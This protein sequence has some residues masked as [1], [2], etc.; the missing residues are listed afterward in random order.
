MAEVLQTPTTFSIA[1]NWQTSKYNLR[2]VSQSV[3]L[4]S[5]RETG[6]RGTSFQQYMRLKLFFSRIILNTFGFLLQHLWCEYLGKGLHPCE[7]VFPA[8]ITQGPLPA[9]RPASFP[10]ADQPLPYPAQPLSRL[11]LIQACILLDEVWN[12]LCSTII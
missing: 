8:L 4:S 9:R 1:S 2:L 12:K 7:A 6:P 3:L 5:T 11:P 10:S